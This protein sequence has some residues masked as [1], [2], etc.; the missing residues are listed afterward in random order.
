MRDIIKEEMD[1][2]GMS[3]NDIRSRAVGKVELNNTRK[4]NKKKI[5]KNKKGIV[6]EIVEKNNIIDLKDS[7]PE[8]M[9]RKYKSK[10]MEYFI[11]WECKLFRWFYKIKNSIYI[12]S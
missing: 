1:K 12:I 2:R 3:C 4:K 10:G 9:V 5:R 7:I 6:E 8:I 11:S